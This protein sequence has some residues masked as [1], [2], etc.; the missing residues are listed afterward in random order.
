M[1]LI[2]KTGRK[3]VNLWAAQNIW[4]WSYS[5]CKLTSIEPYNIETH[6][7]LYIAGKQGH[8]IT[9]SMCCPCIQIICILIYFDYNKTL[10]Q[11]LNRQN[12]T[13]ETEGKIDD[14]FFTH[15]KREIKKF[16]FFVWLFFRYFQPKNMVW[17]SKIE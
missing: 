7:E 13:P 4:I 9:H 8:I 14:V 5:E 1:F 16:H 2:M 6:Y 12:V 17:C 3:F 11:V 15:N 10:K